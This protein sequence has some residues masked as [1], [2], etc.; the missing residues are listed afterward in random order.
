[1]NVFTLFS[2]AIVPFFVLFYLLGYLTFVCIYA[3]GG[4][5]SNS[6]K[7]AQHFLAPLMVITMVPWFLA[8]PILQSPDSR[9]AVALSLVPVFTPITMFMRL[10]VS[11]PPAWQIA[12]SVAL[13]LATIWGM[14][15]ATAKIFRVGILSYGKRPSVGQLLGWLR[16]A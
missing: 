4:A 5:I 15:W 7:E 12:L 11:E 8:L 9:L 6:E 1:M 14:F 13:S 16:V 10:A 2:P 3:V